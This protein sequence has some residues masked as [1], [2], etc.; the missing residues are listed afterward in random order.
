MSIKRNIFY[1]SL[2]NISSVIFPL[3]T[4]PYIARVLEPDNIGLINFASNYVNYFAIFALLG[5][6]I[7]GM[8]EVAKVR[9]N[10]RKL[11]IL[12]SQLLSLSFFSSLIVSLIYFL[13]VLS[14]RQLMEN[15][16]I[17]LLYGVSIFMS[18]FKIEWYYQGTENFSFITVRSLV[19]RIISLICLFSFVH[20]KSDF[21][22]F[23]VISV[24]GGVVGDLWNFMKMLNSG[25]HPFLTL[26]GL[27][28]HFKPVFLLFFSTIAIS[29]YTIL[30]TMMLGFLREYTEVAY[31]SNAMHITKTILIAISSISIVAVPRISYYIKKMDYENIQ[32]L[33]NKSFS[34]VS[35]LVFPI[36]IGMICIAPI[37]VPLFF[38]DLFAGTIQ[39][40][41]ILSFLFISLGLNNLSGMQVLLGMGYDKLF[42]YSVLL[43]MAANFFLNLL[44]I[45]TMGAV[46]ASISSV[47]GESLILIVTLYFVYKKT[48]IRLTVKLD[49]LRSS[50]GA[51]LLFPLSYFLKLFFNGWF[52]IFIFLLLSL[53]LYLYVEFLLRNQS[54][55][56]FYSIIKPYK[57]KFFSF[58]F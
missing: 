26:K 56:I 11:E 34:F 3:I 43:G 17:F 45:P 25:L 32:L 21:V 38:G 47:V 37:F 2:L 58:L 55:Y 30:D 54:L 7:Y 20:E 50:L 42:M 1:N 41:I 4:A 19:I 57:N 35:F 15:R 12:V 24:L 6:P 31:Y 49:I 39:P 10:P 40:L 28:S 44:F 18:P 13:S 5:I 14:I 23:V 16:L 33:V 8:R 52:Y 9:D 53:F 27:L 22:L 36:T 29:I 46:G 48:P 51:I